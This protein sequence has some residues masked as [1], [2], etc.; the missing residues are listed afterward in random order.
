MVTAAETLRRL[1]SMTEETATADHGRIKRVIEPVPGVPDP[2]LLA[3][4]LAGLAPPLVPLTVEQYRAMIEAGILPERAPVELIDGL[5]MWKDRRDDGGDLMTEGDRHYL[6]KHLLRDV[7]DPL[8]RPL[9]FHVVIEPPIL[10]PDSGVPEPDLAVLRGRLLDYRGRLPSANDAAILIE[11]AW[12]SLRFDRQRKLNRYAAAGVPAYWVVDLAAAAV[13]VYSQPDLKRS[14]YG[15]LET[16]E[17]SATIPLSLDET[18][19][20]EVP[21][22]QFLPE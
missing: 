2:R 14:Q 11:I 16:Y 4:I 6:V 18:T 20:V 8:V 12:S 3:D 13:E 7:L 5:L 9:N 10:L 17:R 22:A 1:S 19:A 15:C 21:V